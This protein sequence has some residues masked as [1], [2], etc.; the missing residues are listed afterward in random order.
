MSTVK[1]EVVEIEAVHPH[2]NADRLEV[3]KIKGW[4]CVVG[5]GQFKPG[6]RAVYFPIDSVLPK[7]LEE[8]LFPPSS[9]ITLSKGRVKTIKIRGM[10]SQGLLVRPEQVGMGYAPVGTD[11]TKALGVTKYEPELSTMPKNMMPTAKRHR[12]PHFKEYTDIENGKNYPK[13][14]RDG[15]RVMAT[16]KIHGC[17]QGDTPITLVDGTRKTIREIVENKMDV[18]VWGVNEVGQL[19]PSHVSNWFNNGVET[20]WK[21]V[22]F[23]RK[24]MGRGN[25]FGTI[26]CTSNHKFLVPTD[27]SYRS[28]SDLVNGDA[29][30]CLRSNIQLSYVQ[31]QVLIGKMLGDGSLSSSSVTFAHKKTHQD[32]LSYTLLC[33]GDIAGSIQKKEV[34]SGYGTTMCRARTISNFAISDLFNDW[35]D[36]GR[37]QVPSTIIGKLGPIALAFW[38]MDD[39]SLGHTEDQEDRAGF[40]TCGFDEESIKN[41]IAALAA[42]DIIGTPFFHADY[43]R[44]RLNA[45]EAE[46]LFVLISPYIPQ[47]MRYKL[48]IRYRDLQHCPILTQSSTYKPNLVK[49]TVLSIEDISIPNLNQHKYDITTST[50]NFVADNV[51]V[52]NSNFR[53]GWVPYIPESLW[54]RITHYLFPQWSPCYEFVYG[55]RRVQLQKK[56]YNGFYAE[57]VYGK[58]VTQYNL[59]TIIPHGF[60]IYGEIYGDGIQKGYT[61][62]LGHGEHALV[63]FEVFDTQRGCYLTPHE[64]V[65]FTQNT[66]LPLVPI[67][68]EGEFSMEKMKTLTV[69]PSVIHSSQV[70]R[71][72]VVVRSHEE[73]HC[74]YGR[75]ILKFISDEYLLKDQTDFH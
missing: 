9:K 27:G 54:Q 64:I 39:G 63:L 25:H 29:I 28:C 70:V 53:C 36:G 73:D 37:K 45:D 32:Y 10:V 40:A 21:K 50:H 41:L 38:Y 42:L 23:T 19:V 22:K 69:G 61:Y 11:G 24:N 33:L 14:F 26:I 48:P 31:T 35:N 72:G 51:V 59:E 15:E 49:Q 66:H 17:L 44:I 75:K 58:M 30:L 47:I 18:D 20:N 62:G 16:E 56:L 67:L 7:D 57:N 34:V 2:E 13:M 4:Y 71:E 8:T 6:D 1:V 55:S 65:K 5:K 74:L 3:A 46:K 68:Y 43:W 12:N 52:H 60:I